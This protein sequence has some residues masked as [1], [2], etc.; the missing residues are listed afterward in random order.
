MW[1][2]YKVR[3]VLEGKAVVRVVDVDWDEKSAL[4]QQQT[5]STL[6][7]GLEESMKSMSLGPTTPPATAQQTDKAAACSAMCHAAAGVFH[8]LRK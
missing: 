3:R 5:S 6:G 4:R 1:D 7:L 8:N 2:A